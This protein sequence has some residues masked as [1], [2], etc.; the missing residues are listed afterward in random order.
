MPWAIFFLGKKLKFP[1]IEDTAPQC[2]VDLEA[3]VQAHHD[4]R[5]ECIL[6]PNQFGCQVVREH[7]PRVRVNT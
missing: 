2:S 7:L 6:I 3:L 1:D 5:D 4:K